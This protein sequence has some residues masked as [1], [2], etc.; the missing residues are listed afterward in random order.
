MR[1]GSDAEDIL[2]NTR[3][4]V[5]R[6]LRLSGIGRVDP[7]IGIRIREGPFGRSIVDHAYTSLKR[8]ESTQ[9]PPRIRG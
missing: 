6:D 3:A 2:L 7:I 8:V 4:H 1:L 9:H 5:D